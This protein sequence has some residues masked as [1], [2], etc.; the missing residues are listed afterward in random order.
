MLPLGCPSDRDYVGHDG[1][2]H[3]PPRCAA[4][5]ANFGAV[6]FQFRV[7]PQLMGEGLKWALVIG[8]LGGLFPAL[9]AAR[10]P[11]TDALRELSRC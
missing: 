10:I 4:G 9:R 11:V 5:C 8:F 3:A 1:S 7:T 2:R 6:M